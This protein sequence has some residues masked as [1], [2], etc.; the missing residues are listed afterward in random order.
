MSESTK[1]AAQSAPEGGAR[2]NVSP[3]RLV[4]VLLI[5]AVVA[6]A[7]GIGTGAALW[8]TSGPPASQP[9][10]LASKLYVLDAASGSAVKTGDTTWRLDLTSTTVLWFQDRPHRASG[11]QTV[12]SLVGQWPKLFAGSAPNAAV[13]APGG[14]RGH[15]P[16]AVRVT[17]PVY[18]ASTGVASFTL[19]PDPSETNADAGWIRGLTAGTAAANG[20]VI[21]FVDNANPVPE[22]RGAGSCAI[23][24]RVGVNQVV[25]CSPNAYLENS[26]IPRSDM[27]SSNFEGTKFPGSY[28]NG[29]SFFG[30]DL[31]GACLQ[32]ATLPDGTTFQSSANC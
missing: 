28:F 5:T 11:I 23:S 2:P 3:G 24:N 32:G 21:L 14:P 4:T 31:S 9:Q 27:Q 10:G 22:A 16:T 30:V 20:R 6:A 1:V 29:A 8:R 17:E 12:A 25:S 19:R 7:A 18:S 13:V 15:Q 26:T